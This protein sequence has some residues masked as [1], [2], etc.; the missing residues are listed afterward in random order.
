[1]KN[2]RLLLANSW[3]ARNIDGQMPLNL[4]YLAGAFRSS[5]PLAD[6]V[7]VRIC[8]LNI[9]KKPKEALGEILE[10]FKP[11]HVGVT[12]YSPN[13][14]NSVEV[15]K[16]A[17]EYDGNIVTITGGHHE[18]SC[19]G[20]TRRL[21]PWIDHVVSDRIGEPA[22]VKIVAGEK[23]GVEWQ[24]IY[25]AYDLLAVEDG[26]YQFHQSVFNGKPMVPLMSSRGC[27]YSCKFCGSGEYME[28]PIATVISQ[29][30]KIVESGKQAVFF[31]D[32]NFVSGRE[33]TNALVEGMKNEGLGKRLEWGFQTMAENLS[34]PLIARMSEAG[35]GYFAS[36][37]ENVSPEMLMG[38]NKRITLEAVESACRFARQHSAKV[39]LY[40]MFG[41][42]ESEKQDFEMAVKTL[43]ALEK[44]APDFVSYSI[45]AKYPNANWIGNYEAFEA[46]SGPAWQFFDE[47]QAYHPHCSDAH[48][49]RLMEEVEK[50]H[51]QGLKNTVIF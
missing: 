29:L 28:M 47:G 10:K 5:K 35:L 50:R 4:A 18:R 42:H 17:K 23:F 25:P 48:A 38:Q 21:Y 16:Q 6:S 7:E 31:N 22:L 24:K 41:I 11:T 19:A 49:M 44:I 3:F 51:A 1:M 20:E 45:L 8:D 36:S 14:K 26:S 39:G 2:V 9:E 13:C 30:W 43:D 27:K 34:E 33:R 37:M 12:R 15:L 46:S 32:P 40:V